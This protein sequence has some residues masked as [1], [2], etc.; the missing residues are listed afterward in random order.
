M[1]FERGG[2]NAHALFYN[3]ELFETFDVPPPTHDMSWDEVIE[4]ARNVTGDVGGTRVYGLDMGDC[5]LLKMQMGLTCLDPD[6]HE[7]R[8]REPE[9]QPFFRIVRDAYGIPGG[10]QETDERLFVFGKSFKRK[11]NVAMSVHCP[12]CL[13]GGAPFRMGLVSFPRYGE[14]KR[15]PSGTR[16]TFLAL[17]PKSKRKER[18][19]EVMTYLASEPLQM[20]LARRGHVPA[21]R[22]SLYAEQYGSETPLVSGDGGSLSW[23]FEQEDEVW[24]PVE[25]SNY[26]WQASRIVKEEMVRAVRKEADWGGAIDRMEER[27]E[28]MLAAAGPS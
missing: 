13:S 17:H 21:I 12:Q 10:Y 24:F 26:E 27:I 16:A 20:H 9:W 5:T 4:L 7:S 15:M 6:T 28:A 1:P 25:Q 11:G 18:A 14:R 22:R 8:L 19:V 23:L 3:A 2:T